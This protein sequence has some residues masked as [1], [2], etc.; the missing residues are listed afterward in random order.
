M[1][2]IPST[3]YVHRLLDEAYS[4]IEMTPD[5]QDLKEEMRADLTVRAAELEQSGLSPEAAARRAIDDLGD[6]A[7]IV[8]ETRRVV[9]PVSP[10][11]AARV[12]PRPAFVVRTVLLSAVALA[13]LVVIGFGL[14]G[15]GVK[16]NATVGAAAVLTVVTA[17]VVADS[18]RQETTASYPLPRGRAIRYGLAAG[19]G[20]GGAAAAAMYVPDAKLPWLVGGGIAVLL[21]IVAFT[22]LGVTQTNRH[23]PW[24]VRMQIEHAEV[25]DRFTRD[26]AAAARF[27]IYTVV[28][29]IVAIVGFVALSFAIGWAWSWLALVAG[30]VVFMVMLARMLFGPEQRSTG[31]PVA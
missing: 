22:Y 31:S 6:I 14:T 5:V 29:W 30:L 23:K 10:W 27:G 11:V 21:S 16:L 7:S 19:L 24:A 18:L 1:T 4:G 8:D 15:H 9:G 17:I 28:I 20:I 2:T 26:P 3:L 25:A 12:R 13:A